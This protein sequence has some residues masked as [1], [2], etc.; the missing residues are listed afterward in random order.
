[1]STV[2]KLL[3]LKGNEIL[4]IGPKQTVLE[5]VKIMGEK[6]AG[7]LLVLDTKGKLTGLVS[8]RDC[9]RKVIAQAKDPAKTLVKDIMSKSLTTVQSDTKIEICMGLMTEKR[10]RHLP[11]VEK[12]A[13][14][15]IISIGDV[16]K[17]MVSEKDFIIKNLEKYITGG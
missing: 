5:A 11:V 1:M 3:S 8:E 16:V 14:L 2:A 10:I 17:F 4:S 12:G 15:G 9:I 13:L 7:C 6:S